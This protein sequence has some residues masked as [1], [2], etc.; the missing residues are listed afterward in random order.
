MTRMIQLFPS[1]SL[2]RAT[3]TLLLLAPLP[4]LA[5]SA[6][7]TAGHDRGI[8]F[9]QARSSPYGS[10]AIVGNAQLEDQTIA[11]FKKLG[12]TTVYGSYVFT[13]ETDLAVLRQWNRKLTTNGITSY[14][15]LS[16]VEAIF[17]ARWTSASKVTQTEFVEFN[18]EAK[19]EE[20]FAGLAFDIEPHI[21]T[22]ATEHP[23]WK[24]A[25]N[26]QR[27]QYVGDLLLFLQKTRAQLDANGEKSALIQT[28]LTNWYSKLG[29][30]I[31]WK[32]SEDRDA[33]FTQLAEVC[34][35]V[36]IMDFEIPSTTVILQRNA[37][38]S[39]L[40]HGKA[41]IALRANLGKEWKS[42]EDFWSAVQAVE[43]QTNQSIDIQAYAVLHTN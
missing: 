17:P 13:P 32:N 5:Q 18:K 35:R 19:P 10:T 9:W 20:R 6:T 38:E 12:V 34:T 21:L 22:T 3:A 42:S 25:T 8:W 4:A 28:S 29:E 24:D 11:N 27:R 33:W 16:D 15:L 2:L 39:R 30:R 40:L 41:R 36:S 31:E 43:T 26:E 23:S 7:P 1:R 14:L 37:E